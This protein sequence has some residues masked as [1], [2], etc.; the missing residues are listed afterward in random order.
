MVF[1]IENDTPVIR[2]KKSRV[3]IEIS[4]KAKKYKRKIISNSIKNHH[5]NTKTQCPRY[6][7]KKELKIK[8][9]N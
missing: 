2:I 1:S 9:I 6:Q 8:I 5:S 7:I 4:E 3:F